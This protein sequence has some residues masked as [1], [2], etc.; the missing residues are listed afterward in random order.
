MEK[1]H[2]V[3]SLNRE[4][5]AFENVSQMCKRFGV[6][7]EFTDAQL[8]YVADRRRIEYRAEGEVLYCSN[9]YQVGVQQGILYLLTYRTK[10]WLR[11]G[12]ACESVTSPELVIATRVAPDGHARSMEIWISYDGRGGLEKPSCVEK[13]LEKYPAP[14][15]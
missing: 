4:A 7:G 8:A 10:S 2:T 12:E 13:L 5:G 14:W 3:E 11:G 6:T 9:T 1:R 15:E